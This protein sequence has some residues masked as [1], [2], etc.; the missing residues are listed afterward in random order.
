[1][2]IELRVIHFDFCL[3]DKYKISMSKSRNDKD[4]YCES[5]LNVKQYPKWLLKA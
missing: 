5:F 4:L 2:E 1:M 3:F